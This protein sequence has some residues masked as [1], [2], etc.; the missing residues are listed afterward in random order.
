MIG[1]GECSQEYV[2]EF[3]QE[4]GGV[5]SAFSSFEKCPNH[6]AALF[7]HLG[8]ALPIGSLHA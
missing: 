3:G 2:S 5:C 6:F 7:T 8:Y 1:G 4:V